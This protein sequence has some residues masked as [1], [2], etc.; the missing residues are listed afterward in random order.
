[1]NDKNIEIQIIHTKAMEKDNG[2]GVRVLIDNEDI[3]ILD[4]EKE[5]MLHIGAILLHASNTFIQCS[6]I[7]LAKDICKNDKERSNTYCQ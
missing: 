5:D 2:F 4:L 7:Q 3:S 6:K 1:M